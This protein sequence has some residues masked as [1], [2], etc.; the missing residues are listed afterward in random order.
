MEMSAGSHCCVQISL[1]FQ[2]IDSENEALLAAL[3]ET[4]DEIQED[5]MG[6]AAFRTMEE[7]DVPNHTCAS[8]A[9]S[10]KPV[11]PTP[12]GPPLAPE[13]DE[14]SLVRTHFLLFKVDLDEPLI[15]RL[16]GYDRKQRSE[17]FHYRLKTLNRRYKAYTCIVYVYMC[18]AI[19]VTSITILMGTS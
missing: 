5:D 2:I 15:S 1:A 12:G 16:H 10:P 3:T 4:L 8:P 13:V 7:R 6:L 9:P 18:R 17:S 14:L 19:T 11:A